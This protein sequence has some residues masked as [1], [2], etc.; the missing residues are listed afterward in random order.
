MYH[1]LLKRI[2]NPHALLIILH[3]ILSKT[4]KFICN[5]IRT[6]SCMYVKYL[7]NLFDGNR[8]KSRCKEFS[9]FGHIY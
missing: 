1:I 7:E 5:T 8:R 3:F 2:H 9:H 4:V 6:M